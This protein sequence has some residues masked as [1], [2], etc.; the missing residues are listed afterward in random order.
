[1]SAIALVPSGRVGSVTAFG[2]TAG[3]AANAT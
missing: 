1:M 3:S 2:F